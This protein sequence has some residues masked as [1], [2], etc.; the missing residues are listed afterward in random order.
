M[1]K[2]P[3]PIFN[4]R[5]VNL[6]ED[7]DEVFSEPNPFGFDFAFDSFS[8]PN[9]PNVSFFMPDDYDTTFSF[10]FDPNSG[11]EYMD[12]VADQNSF[13][14]AGRGGEE[15]DD[16][17]MNFT[18]NLFRARV[19][20]D[21]IWESGS[22][23]GED[24]GLEF[25]FCQ[26]L[27]S[28]EVPSMVGLRVAGIESDSDSEEFEVDSGF[29]NDDD[30][31]D[32]V[33]FNYHINESERAL[34]EEY[35][36]EEVNE[37]IQF[38]ERE[39]LN[40]VIDRIEEMNLN[41]V[42]DRIE[43]ISVSSEISS[44]EDDNLRLSDDGGGDDEA[45][46]I[47]WEVLLGRSNLD[48][49]LVMENVGANIN[50]NEILNALDDYLLTMDYDNL[51]GQFVENENGLKG[52]PPAAKSV[53]ENLASLVLTKEETGA[54]NNVVV[55]AVCKDEVAIGEK[56][57][58]MPCSHLYHGD[59]ILPWLRIR[60]TCPV[61]RYELPTDNADYEKRRSERSDHG[62]AARFVDD[63]QVRYN[64]ELLP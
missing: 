2:T 50:R 35:E 60:N 40:S 54:N 47:E 15:Y 39:N 59:C 49:N 57:T 9:D 26:D 19:H 4:N 5:G 28:V 41:S 42:I 61:C 32:N 58:R 22:L 64:F 1:Q 31:Y 37:R 45:R 33:G 62:I 56:V 29:D 48:T 7:E 44:S 55:C 10:T 24:L 21:Q 23:P 12:S 46:N 30:N 34:T 8:P 16:E 20:N 17:Q 11:S 43:E 53:V 63:L 25:G 13:F 6:Q 27:G 3:M 51:F 14:Y 18:S 52:S 38:D 36:W